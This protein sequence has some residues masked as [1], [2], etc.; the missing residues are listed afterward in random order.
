VTLAERS[1]GGPPPE[2]ESTGRYMITDDCTRCGVCEYMCPQDAIKEA[3]NQ[4]VIRR[5]LCDGC[6]ECV[7]YCPV[8][9]IVPAS[10][11]AARQQDTRKAQ[12]RRILKR[13]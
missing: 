9:A 5:H 13:T 12:L 6:A 2:E 1:P 3:P 8:R 7:P 4:F 10:E 11:F